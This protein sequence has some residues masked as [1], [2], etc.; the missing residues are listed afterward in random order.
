MSDGLVVASAGN[1]DPE[2]DAAH[3]SN[4]FRGSYTMPDQGVWLFPIDHRGIPLIGIARSDEA[5]KEERSIRM[6]EEIQL[7]FEHGL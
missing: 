5:I 7:L 4:L 3:Y 6:A 1:S 2:Y